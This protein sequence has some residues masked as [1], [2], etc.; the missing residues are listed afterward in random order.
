MHSSKIQWRHSIDIKRIFDHLLYLFSPS[1]FLAILYFVFSLGCPVVTE[2]TSL[3]FHALKG[4]PGPYIKVRTILIWFIIII[5]HLS[6]H[7]NFRVFFFYYF[8][9]YCTALYCTGLFIFSS[10]MQLRL[11]FF[12]S[13]LITFHMV[14]YDFEHYSHLVQSVLTYLNVI[15]LSVTFSSGFLRSSDTRDWTT[16]WWHIRIKVPMHNAL[17]HTARDQVTR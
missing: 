17:S 9:L 12:D 3:C 1:Y 2:D 5:Y 6:C 16:C 8:V 10:S 7:I 11:C 4:L 14:W 13:N 15:F